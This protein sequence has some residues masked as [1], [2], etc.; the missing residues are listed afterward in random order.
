MYNFTFGTYNGLFVE[1]ETPAVLPNDI[2]YFDFRRRN[3]RAIPDDSSPNVVIR[4]IFSDD[5]ENAGELLL[6]ALI[7]KAQEGVRE[8]FIGFGSILTENHT[9]TNIKAA[10]QNA[11]SL[12]NKSSDYFSEGKI[13]NRPKTNSSEKLDLRDL[14]IKGEVD[15]FGQIK[16]TLSDPQTSDV[17]ARVAEAL[18]KGLD[19][20]EIVINENSGLEASEI[21][22]FLEEQKNKQDRAKQQKK[23]AKQKAINEE[24]LRK[25]AA[26]NPKNSNT[27]LIIGIS[28]AAISVLCAALIVFLIFRTGPSNTTNNS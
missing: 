16:E 23:Q 19:S 24:K 11:I 12:A 3:R 14:P 15:C 18:F 8:G 2:S 22:P 13:L 26:D 20:F 17:L 1:C 27:A 21:G 25:F 5:D 9:K 4:K 6:V 7:Y 28:L 10:L